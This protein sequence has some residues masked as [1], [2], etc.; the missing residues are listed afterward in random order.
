MENAVRERQVD[1]VICNSG[2]YVDYA[3]KYAI[4]AITTSERS[5]GAH[6]S[7]LFGGAVVVQAENS[8]IKTFADLRG[9]RLAAVDPTS[10]GGCSLRSGSSSAR[11]SIRRWISRV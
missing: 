4:R 7:S 6:S 1:F 9:K 5:F 8:E 11:G 3:A 2:L 10:F